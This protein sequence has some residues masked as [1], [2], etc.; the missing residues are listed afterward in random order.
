[1]SRGK[2]SVLACKQWPEGY[3]YKFNCYGR[4]PEPWGQEDYDAG[5]PYDDKTMF[6]DYDE[7]GYDRYGYSAFD[8]NGVFVGHGQGV[9]RAGWTEMDY[10]TLRDIPE[11][12]R[13]TF[14]D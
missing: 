5:R 2:Y 10:L 8:A 12:E 3:E 13:D 6:G 11:D 4:I 14:W 7:E 9:D 1:M